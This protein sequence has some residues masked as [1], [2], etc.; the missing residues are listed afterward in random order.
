MSSDAPNLPEDSIHFEDGKRLK[1]SLFNGKP[2]RDLERWTEGRVGRSPETAAYSASSEDDQIAGDQAIR[3]YNFRASAFTEVHRLQVEDF[4]SVLP[5]TNMGYGTK[6]VEPSPVPGGSLRFHCWKRPES[7]FM[8]FKA[9]TAS[10]NGPISRQALLM[11]T[12]LN[13]KTEDQMKLGN[14]SLFVEGFEEVMPK[15]MLTFSG[16]GRG[17]LKGWN[18][19]TTLLFDVPPPSFGGNG[20][21]SGQVVFR[22]SELFVIVS[23]ALD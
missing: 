13:L 16:I 1:K 11:R 22:A 15:S 14:G 19:I 8:Y 18:S 23:Y 5:E 7:I 10:V 20:T 12:Y 21:R 4:F 6:G 9:I 2:I 3:G 17:G